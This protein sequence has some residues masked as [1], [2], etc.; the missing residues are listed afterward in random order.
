[1]VALPQA[2]CPEIIIGDQMLG[3]EILAL[4]PAPWPEIIIGINV[5]YRNR[6]ITAGFLN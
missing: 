1:M 5:R 3:T 4:P 2:P 6:G